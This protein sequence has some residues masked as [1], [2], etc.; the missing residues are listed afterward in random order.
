MLL[1]MFAPPPLV[2]VGAS[3]APLTSYCFGNG[4]GGVF[5]SGG[6]GRFA[7][8]GADKFN[9]GGL[10]AGRCMPEDIARSAGGGFAGQ[11]LVLG[12]GRVGL[13]G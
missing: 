3:A 13:G 12:G 11:S 2:A 5:P 7:A 1:E 6:G 9:G 10:F 8:G 4:G